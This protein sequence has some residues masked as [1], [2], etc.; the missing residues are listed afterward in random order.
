[1]TDDVRFDDELPET[2]PTKNGRRQA[3]RSPAYPAIDLGR[4]VA[5]ARVIWDMEKQYQMSPETVMKHWNYTSLNGPAGLQLSAL[6]K[7]GLMDDQGTKKDRRVRLT[8]LAVTILNH[9]NEDE[10][11]RGIRIAAL[12]PQVHRE[13]WDEYGLDLPSDTNLMWNLTRERGFTE[14][15]AK[16]FIK[17]YRATLAY[18]RMDESDASE[19]LD[20]GPDS[21][22]PPASLAGF[23]PQPVNAE[24][25]VPRTE[26]YV[27]ARPPSVE[28]SVSG[29]WAV[30]RQ[31]GSGRH[32]TQ[33][34]ISAV[35]RFPIPLPGNRGQVVIEG[36]FPMSEAEW[37]YFLA[38]LQAMKPGFVQEPTPRPVPSADEYGDHD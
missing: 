17:E 5:R 9:P 4:A 2:T 23:T 3:G 29:Q 25:K 1:M 6:V 38:V 10:R 13:M 28:G 19:L 21:D 16:E 7:F 36:P 30:L 8:D 14:S 32:G 31:P 20:D 15:G 37:T 22:I 34:V 18:A 33:A 11:Q 24:V 26:L 27:G 35:P 12:A